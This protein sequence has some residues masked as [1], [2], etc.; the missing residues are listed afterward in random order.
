MRDEG[1]SRHIK[2]SAVIKYLIN[3]G[4]IISKEYQCLIIWSLSINIGRIKTL[5]WYSNQNCLW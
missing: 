4:W 1:N 2:K 5:I 3:K